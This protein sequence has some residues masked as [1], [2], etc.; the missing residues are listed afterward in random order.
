MTASSQ[1]SVVPAS[2]ASQPSSNQRADFARTAMAILVAMLLL[3]VALTGILVE[4][5]WGRPV[6][7]VEAMPAEPGSVARR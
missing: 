1:T 3:I 7:Q 2:S 6:G 4:T 5:T